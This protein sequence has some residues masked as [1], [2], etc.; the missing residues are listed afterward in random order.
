MI[1]ADDPIAFGGLIGG[2]RLDGEHKVICGLNALIGCARLNAKK[3]LGLCH[4]FGNSH[5]LSPFLIILKLDLN[6]KTAGV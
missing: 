6:L 3:F 5:V 1:G 4:C 2:V